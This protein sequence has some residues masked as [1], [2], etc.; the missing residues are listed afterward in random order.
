MSIPKLAFGTNRTL[1]S[2]PHADGPKLI[3]AIEAAL[4]SL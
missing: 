3:E 2:V 4:P 1:A